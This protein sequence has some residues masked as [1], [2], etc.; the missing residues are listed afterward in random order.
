MGFRRRSSK[1]AIIT[2]VMRSGVD[3]SGTWLTMLRMWTRGARS[4]R[5]PDLRQT[6]AKLQLYCGHVPFE[7]WIVAENY[8]HHPDLHPLRFPGSWR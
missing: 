1:P 5:F 2:T 4:L 8:Q 7:A 3:G 6:V